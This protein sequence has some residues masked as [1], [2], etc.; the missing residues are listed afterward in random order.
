MKRFFLWFSLTILVLLVAALLGFRYW[1]LSYLRSEPCRLLASEAAS[2]ALGA[3]AAF[4]LFQADSLDSVYADS[5]SA[6][7][8]PG[9]R[10]IQADQLRADVRFGFLSRRCTVESLEIARLRLIAGDPAAPASQP[11]MPAPAKANA[12]SSGAFSLD[13]VEVRLLEMGWNGGTVT[14][15]SLVATPSPEGEWLAE[16]QGGTFRPSLGPEWKLDT[17][18]GRQRRDGFHLTEAKLRSGEKGTARVEGVFGEDAQCRA[19][20]EGVA[21]SA[22]LPEDWRARIVGALGG[23]LKFVGK[24]SGMTLSEGRLTITDGEV[25]TLPIFDLVARLTRIDGFR[26][27]RL[28]KAQ[29]RVVQSDG[30]LEVRD[31]VVESTGLL[32]LEGSFTIRDG[33]ISGTLQAGVSESALQWIPGARETLF[34]TSRDGYVWTPVKL[35]G[36]AAHPQEDFTARLA[37]LAV[38]GAAGAAGE[39]LDATVDKVQDGTKK[40]IDLFSPLLPSPVR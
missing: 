16:G 11:P 18:R 17:F 28:H 3:Q 20:F 24:G 10:L 21:L 27:M 32:R 12:P 9:Y 5:F 33:E 2:R 29:A 35:S 13:R 15:S 38:S 36:L 7:N 19:T 8:G 30:V 14:G 6:R 26:K 4:T 39:V 23:E 31:F 1:F 34:T 40:V 25:V 37:A 22:L